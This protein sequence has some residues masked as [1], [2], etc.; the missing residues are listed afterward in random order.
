LAGTGNLGTVCRRLPGGQEAIKMIPGT[1]R[2]GTCPGRCL[3]V[4]G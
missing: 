3:P 4:L 1:A 2:P